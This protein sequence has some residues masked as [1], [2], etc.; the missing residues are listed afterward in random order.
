MLYVGL[1]VREFKM[2]ATKR[3]SFCKDF[4]LKVTNWY[5]ENWKN[6]SQTAN[7]FQ[8]NQKQVRNR[9]KNEEKFRSLKRSKKACQYGK[10]KRKGT[11][12]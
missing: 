3:R 6:I 1:H 9:L 5:S 10:A 8:I 12:H 4:K 11:S 2:A 7:K